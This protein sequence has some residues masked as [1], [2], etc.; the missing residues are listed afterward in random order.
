MTAFTNLAK[1]S[2][3][4]QRERCPIASTS[5]PQVP[6]EVVAKYVHLSASALGSHKPHPKDL[7]NLCSYLACQNLFIDKWDPLILKLQNPESVKPYSLFQ[8]KKRD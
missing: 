7:H 1:S 2:A 4:Q 5:A 8:G 6:L 3:T